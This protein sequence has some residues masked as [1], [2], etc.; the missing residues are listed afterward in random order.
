MSAITNIKCTSCG[1]NN[2]TLTHKIFKFLCAVCYL[3][4]QKK[5]KICN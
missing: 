5:G 1:C 3:K 4:K 2:A